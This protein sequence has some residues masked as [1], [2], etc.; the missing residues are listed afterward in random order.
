MGIVARF[1]D[2]SS[3]FARISLGLLGPPTELSSGAVDEPGVATLTDLE[4]L[5][6]QFLLG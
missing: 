3:S 4:D 1:G 5:T 2:A 6:V